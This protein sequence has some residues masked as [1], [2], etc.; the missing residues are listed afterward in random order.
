MSQL[1]FDIWNEIMQ[2][3]SGCRFREI[4]HLYCPGCG[5]TRAM[6]EL[7]HMHLL[8]SLYYNPLPVYLLI[9]GILTMGTIL[10]ESIQL[11]Y[12]GILGLAIIGNTIKI[13][14]PRIYNFL[15]SKFDYSHNVF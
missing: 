1:S 2:M 3:I 10:L 8:K 13:R 4:Y 7:L 12:R 9:D 6:I 11:L 14:I 15:I 5:G